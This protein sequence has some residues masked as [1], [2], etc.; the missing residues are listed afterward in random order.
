MSKRLTASIAMAIVALSTGLGLAQQAP[1]Q[2]AKVF[3]IPS[4]GVNFITGDTWEQDDRRMRLY[5]VQSCIRGSFFTNAAG[6]RQ[7]CGEASLTVFAALVRDTHPTCSPLAQIPAY[8][9]NPPVNLVICAAHMGD[10]S[11]DLGT[12]MI[13]Q[14]FGFAAFTNQGEPVYE[15]Y[16]V[17]EAVAKTNRAGLWA[18]PDFIHPNAILF[19]AVNPGK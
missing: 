7:D 4:T 6:I 16:Y 13:V 10:N 9:N 1:S 14:G 15:P 3:A 5:G 2:L 8:Q 19:K 17:A 11:P 18:Y 12:A